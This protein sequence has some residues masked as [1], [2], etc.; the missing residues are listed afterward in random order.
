MTGDNRDASDKRD[1]TPVTSRKPEKNSMS[2]SVMRGPWWAGII[3]ATVL[4]SAIAFALAWSA[5]LGWMRDPGSSSLIDTMVAYAWTGLGASFGPP[6]VLS[7]WW[8]GTT[9]RG[10]LA[11]MIGGMLATIVWQNTAALGA[12][13]DIKAGAVLVSGLLVIVVSKLDRS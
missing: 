7:L 4:M 3:L 10:A 9:R 5:L 2:T 8:R 13:L 12:I 11:G 6:L 1:R